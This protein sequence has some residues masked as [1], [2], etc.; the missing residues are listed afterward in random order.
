MLRHKASTLTIDFAYAAWWC[1]RT[2]TTNPS[3][4]RGHHQAE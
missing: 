3:W 4:D 1:R 2:D